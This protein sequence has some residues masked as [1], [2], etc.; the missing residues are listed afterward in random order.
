MYVHTFIHMYNI[1]MSRVHYARPRKDTKRSIL[2]CNCMRACA[3]L[4]ESVRSFLVSS[5][6]CVY[7]RLYVCADTSGLIRRP[8][9]NHGENSWW[10]AKQ[11]APTLEIERCSRSRSLECVFA[12]ARSRGL[13]RSQP[14]F[15]IIMLEK[16]MN[17][18]FINASS[19]F[20]SFYDKKKKVKQ[21]FPI[22]ANPL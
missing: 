12:R 3:G 15:V 19:Y 17:I 1:D 13:S 2:N 11:L 9:A 5:P 18:C 6:C 10:N 21:N 20:I 22:L 4:F 14:V 8:R 7:S 16:C